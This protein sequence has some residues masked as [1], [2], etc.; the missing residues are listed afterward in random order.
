M[1]TAETFP[2][3]SPTS[4]ELELVENT[5]IQTSLNGRETRQQI[6][7]PYWRFSA[8]YSN[9]TDAQRRQISGHIASARGNLLQFQ[10]ALPT[11]VNSNGNT[12]VYQITE[13]VI[14]GGTSFV[15]APQT[16]PEPDFAVG[17]YI[18]IGLD[19]TLNMISKVNEASSIFDP[20]FS[21]EFWPPVLNQHNVG[22]FVYSND[23]TV[24]VRYE[25]DFSQ[26]VRNNLYSS[27]E[28]TFVEV[29]T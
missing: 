1:T 11:P 26:L 14:A 9:L 8:Q 23:L 3:I 6:Q 19:P 16:Y 4:F 22:E 18:K 7:R 10:F 5:I 24:N 15:S 29:L 21:V 27:F 25:S 12:N 2:N 13:Q 28:L 17:D 20:S